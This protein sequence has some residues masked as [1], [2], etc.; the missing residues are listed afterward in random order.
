[1]EQQ[2]HEGS[3]GFKVVG[4]PQLKKWRTPE[5]RRKMAETG[6][7]FIGLQEAARKFEPDTIADPAHG[8]PAGAQN[9]LLFHQWKKDGE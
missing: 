1:M 9:S 8:Q 7:G 3:N 6:N 4:G 2:V 5:E